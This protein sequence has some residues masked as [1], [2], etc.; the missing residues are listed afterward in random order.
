MCSRGRAAPRERRAAFLY[1][2]RYSFGSV[3]MW[4][5]Q[6]QATVLG[7]STCSKYKYRLQFWDHP[8]VASTSTGT[9][10][11]RPHVASTSTGYSWGSSTCSTVT[12]ALAPRTREGAAREGAGDCADDGTRVVRMQ[13]RRCAALAPCVLSGEALARF[14]ALSSTLAR[15]SAAAPLHPHVEKRLPAA[16]KKQQQR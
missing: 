9:V 15:G 8:H 6:V 14:D 10:W 4:H 12:H 5:V 13:R 1:K 7:A 3:H 16:S 2:C 11:D